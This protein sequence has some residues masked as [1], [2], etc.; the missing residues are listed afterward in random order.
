M[1]SWGGTLTPSRGAYNP[2]HE[3]EGR[4][5]SPLVAA[6]GRAAISACSAV[7]KHFKART[8]HAGEV[9]ELLKQIDRGAVQFCQ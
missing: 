3:V 4:T 7:K 9:E 8:D 2:P 1:Y 6:D 5:P